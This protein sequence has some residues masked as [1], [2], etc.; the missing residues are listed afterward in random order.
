MGK[1]TLVLRS[2]LM[3]PDGAVR[4]MVLWR[5]PEFSAERPHQLKYSLYYG[6][7]DGTCLVRY[8]NERGKGDHRHAKG[9]EGP[10]RFIDVEAL[11]ATFREI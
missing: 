9:E 7:P 10:Y 1:A 5:L 6:G 3:Y 11:V 4:E 8:D 2:K